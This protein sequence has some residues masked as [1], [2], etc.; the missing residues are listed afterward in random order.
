MDIEQNMD[1]EQTPTDK[2]TDAATFSLI[3]P[4]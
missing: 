4:G 1:M 2:E 3:L